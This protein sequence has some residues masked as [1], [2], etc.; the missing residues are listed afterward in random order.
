MAAVFLVAGGAAVSQIKP[1]SASGVQAEANAGDS[2]FLMAN[3]PSA[4]TVLAN[5]SIKAASVAPAIAP[6]GVVVRTGDRSVVLHWD[7]SPETS[8][9]GWNVYRSVEVGGPFKKLPLTPA[10]TQS[11]ADMAVTNGLTYYYTVRAIDAFRREGPDSAVVSAT[12]QSFASD[13]EFLDYIQ[14]TGVDYFWYEA[15]PTNGLIRDR[16]QG[17]SMCSIAAVGFGLTAIP[18]GIE[19]GWIPREAGRDRTLV[20]LKTFME[21]PQGSNSSGMIGY[22]GWFYHFLNMDTALRTSSCELS[23][24]DTALFMAGVLYA[25]QYYNGADPSEAA[26]R[27]L[28]GKLYER[29]DWPWMANNSNS[30]AMGWNPGSRFISSRWIGYNE[31]MI[32]YIMGLGAP[33]N[34]L[35]P[36]HWQSWTGGYRWQ[37]NYTYS[38]VGFAPL[39]GHQ[40]SHCWID[41]RH[42]GDDYMN[43]K[44]IS[45][46]ENSRRATLAQRAYA[47]ANPRGFTGYGSNTWGLTA[48][49]GPGYSPYLAYSA[50]GAPPPENDD[51]TL[52]PTAAG[53]SMP[54]TPEYSLPVLRNLYSA[55]REKLWTGYGFR[56]AFNLRANW[57]DPDVLGIDQGPIVLMIENHRS[58]KVWRL[59]MQNPEIQL[60]LQKAGFVSFAF[61]HPALDA[62]DAPETVRLRWPASGNNNYQVEHSPDLDLWFASPTGFLT[63]IGDPLV[64]TDNGPPATP[65]KPNTTAQRFYRVFELGP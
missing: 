45:Y 50:R 6:G 33:T 23:S 27:D 56:D 40:Y 19:H 25:K 20:T 31:A 12:P 57:W 3:G 41:F 24:I 16:T 52:A 59:F 22:K 51:G 21:K 62:G 35:P 55:Y 38:Y 47:I 60:G 32:L 65:L 15:N 7:R 64:W 43:A 8:V 10:P 26:I 49:D 30:L 63:S 29:I 1:E 14:R 34:A 42:M 4:T 48:C 9:T 28:A 36:I 13:D 44:G 17:N 54:F 46:F 11:F 37:T 5:D 2:S 18:I 58:Q 39:F 61:A 53:A